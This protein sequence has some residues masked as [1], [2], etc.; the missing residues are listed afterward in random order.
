MNINHNRLVPGGITYWGDI[1]G[2]ITDQKDLVDYISTHGGG[3]GGGGDAVWGSITGNLSD[4]T[5]LM[6]KLS[7]FATE[8]FVTSA[9]SGYAT[10]SW[11]TSQGYLTEVP[12]GY[13]TESWVSSNFLGSTALSSY[14]TE[15]WVGEQGYLSK[16]DQVVLPLEDQNKFINGLTGSFAVD[17]PGKNTTYGGMNI[18]NIGGE[19]Y[20]Y[21]TSRSSKI[22]KFNKTTFKF[23]LIGDTGVLLEDNYPVWDDGMGNVFIGNKY[24]LDL[25]TLKLS[26][27]DMG[28]NYLYYQGRHNI[29]RIDGQ[30]YMVTQNAAWLYDGVY[31]VFNVEITVS[32]I[33]NANFYRYG[34][35]FYGDQFA[36]TITEN[37]VNVLYKFVHTSGLE[38]TID[39]VTADFFPTS[40]NGTSVGADRTHYIN[41]E[42]VWFN[43]KYVCKLVNGEWTEISGFSKPTFSNNGAGAEFGDLT[44]GYGYGTSN[45]LLVF[46]FNEYAQSTYRFVTDIYDWVAEQGYITS[47]ALSGYATESWV[48]E[49]GYLTSGST[50][51]TDVESRLSSIETTLG[52]A[53]QITNNILS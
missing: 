39:A 48:S 25:T 14:A 28:G 13:A 4:Q 18:F 3:G 21:A 32:G 9:L 12:S 16:D 45:K 46:N 27:H 11:V 19:I 36:Y 38:E 43:N 42:Y 1:V 10:E 37:G 41:G 8:Q 29:I 49:Q 31:Q 33:T 17:D 23:D 52:Q 34:N 35:Y 40:Y 5:D 51:I 47:N 30:L 24:K 20:Y 2:N 15:S 7:E 26:P 22:W 44:F 6:N 53:V 50:T